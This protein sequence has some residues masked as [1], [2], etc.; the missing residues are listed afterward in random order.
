MSLAE[1]IDRPFQ[2]F[3]KGIGSSMLILGAFGAGFFERAPMIVAPLAALFCIAKILSSWR[4][5]SIASRTNRSTT[6]SGKLGVAVLLQ[7]VLVAALYGAG[8]LASSFAGGDP[9]SDVLTG[10]DWVVVVALAVVAL[11]LRI[12]GSSAVEFAAE[13]TLD[14]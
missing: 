4:A 3:F 9:G 10:L 1:T 11:P 12:F 2:A 8:R 7:V 14:V 5:W 6:V 13:T